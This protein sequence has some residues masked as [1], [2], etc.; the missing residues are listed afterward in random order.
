MRTFHVAQVHI[1]RNAL[2]CLFWCIA[3]INMHL[4]LLAASK[5]IAP[6]LTPVLTIGG[7]AMVA[8]KLAR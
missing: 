6:C 5:A 4:G 3:S 2:T 8:S 1:H 7:G